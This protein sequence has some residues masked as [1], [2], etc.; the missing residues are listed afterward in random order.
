[1]RLSTC[2][3][4]IPSWLGTIL[5]CLGRSAAS[6]GLSACIPS[7]IGIS[8]SCPGR[9]A[10]YL[11]RANCMGRSAASLGLSACI[12]CTPS[13]MGISAAFL[14]ITSWLARSPACLGLFAYTAC[15]HPWLGISAACLGKVCLGRG[16][17]CFWGNDTNCL[18]R[19]SCR[20]KST[21]CLGR[22]NPSCPRKSATCLE[23]LKNLYLF[24]VNNPT[25]HRNIGKCNLP[26][27]IT[28][29]LSAK[30]SVISTLTHR[31]KNVCSNP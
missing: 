15:S 2:L 4:C 28:Y 30:Y 25:L 26:H 5:A 22:T 21:T 16:A 24:G 18:V 11:G 8:A 23:I 10:N 12:A 9:N 7:W 31:A 29:H 27:V 13:W 6:L 3:A 14:G 1:M 20:G 19:T 17:T